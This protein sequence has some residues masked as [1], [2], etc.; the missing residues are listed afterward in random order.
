M[1]PANSR[2]WRIITFT[3]AGLPDAAARSRAGRS[4]SG[5]STSSPCPPRASTTYGKV[6]AD[7]RV[8]LHSVQSKGAIAVDDH[9]ALVGIRELGGQGEGHADTQRSERARIHPATLALDRDDLRR[10]GDDVAAIADHDHVAQGVDPVAHLAAHPL[11]IDRDLVGVEL[12]LDL[13]F[14]FVL[15][16]AQLVTPAGVVE[17]DALVLHLLD[18]QLE[19]AGQVAHQR[20]VG[21]AVLADQGRVHVELDHLGV[22][23]NRLAEAHAEV[24]ER[25]CEDDAVDLLH[26]VAARAVQELRRIRRDRAPPHPIHIGGDV[27]L[28]EEA[29]ELARGARPLDAGSGHQHRT[30]AGLED[31]DRLADLVAIGGEARRIGPDSRH[32]HLILL[33]LAHEDVHGDL[34]KGRTRNARHGVA[35]RQLDVLGDPVGLVDRVGVLGDGSHHTD[36]IHLLE[37]A[38]AQVVEGSLTA[39]H[40]DR[41]V[42]PPCVGDAGDAVGDTGARGD[43]RNSDLARVAARP[44]VR[45]VDRRLLVAHV[46][47][48]DALVDAAIVERHDV[49]AGERED[50]L[51][52]GF[53]ERLGCELSTVEG[54]GSV[55]R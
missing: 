2:S 18:Q 37:R 23:W 50:A 55:P 38:A 43:R 11:G 14:R 28:L 10:G 41:R 31:L 21:L 13:G 19:G 4:S 1:P 40:E 54:H 6:E 49:T 20:H 3:S 35:H 32:H 7:R 15:D 42:G 53:L 46:D 47:D 33:D 30:L 25:A 27:G 12:G 8:E 26:G 39:N 51:D 36:V 52:A 16:H 34:E 22:G 29:V 9:D 5:D 24:E 48:L 45:R 17:V 44:G